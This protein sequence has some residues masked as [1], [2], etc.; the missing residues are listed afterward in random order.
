MLKRSGV[1]DDFGDTDLGL[2]LVGGVE[3]DG[4]G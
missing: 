1:G 4:L 3:Q 2:G